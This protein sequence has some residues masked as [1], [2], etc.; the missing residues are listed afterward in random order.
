MKKGKRAQCHCTVAQCLA[1]VIFLQNILAANS[2]EGLQGGATR[3]QAI[4]TVGEG[5][6]S[7]SAS[8]RERLDRMHGD[9][10][11]TATSLDSRA[12][13]LTK[14]S[15]A[16]PLLSHLEKHGGVSVVHCIDATALESSAC[17]LYGP[18][19]LIIFNFPHLGTEDFYKHQFLIAHFFDSAKTLLDLQGQVQIALANDQPWRW[20]VEE[21]AALSGF[22]LLEARTFRPQLEFP[23]YLVRRHHSGKSFQRTRPAG[24]LRV[25]MRAYRFTFVRAARIP[26]VWKAG[27][28][29]ST[30]VSACT[31]PATNET[32]SSVSEAEIKVYLPA[33]NFTLWCGKVQVDSTM[34]PGGDLARSTEQPAAVTPAE[35]A[36]DSHPELRPSSRP[37]L[38]ALESSMLLPC[39]ACPGREF[40][41]A[42]ALRQHRRAKHGKYSELKPDWFTHPTAVEASGIRASSSRAHVY[43]AETGSQGSDG[44]GLVGQ[45]WLCRV[46]RIEF[47]NETQLRNHL[48]GLQ[49]AARQVHTCVGCNR[50]F[51]EQR[52]LLQHANFCSRSCT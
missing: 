13:V 7:F 31:A 8:L 34:T 30:D 51:N 25:D 37:E 39:T 42:A 10:H 32:L 45:M 18:Y 49:P 26:G 24:N 19:D 23:G 44:A 12:T 48:S 28:S 40:R 16:L 9:Y 41:C 17:A 4:L 29:S 35:Q 2:R 47:G 38:Q 50:S 14:Y 11:L 52:A 21:M 6:F 33:Y 3:P 5:D 46:C 43:G 22:R 36:L 15:E 27:A 1:L 20:A